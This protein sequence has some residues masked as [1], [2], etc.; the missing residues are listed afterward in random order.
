P[1]MTV[2]A[3]RDGQELEAMLRF[4]AAHTKG[5]IA[6]RYPRGAV[7]E[8]TG[9][10]LKDIVSAPIQEGRAE[11]LRQGKDAAF[12]AYGSM[13]YPAYEAAEHLSKEGIEVTVVNAR[14]VKPL[15]EDL[16]KA[17]A[18][19]TKLFVTLEEGS[20]QGGFGSAVLEF[21][22]NAQNSGHLTAAPRVR[23]L[24]IPDRFIEHGKRDVLMDSI[25]LSAQKIK[26]EALRLLRPSA[27]EALQAT[28]GTNG[29]HTQKE[30][31]QKL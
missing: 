15:D 7:A 25:G 29:H 30:L 8:E 21:F 11:I 18:K 22:E 26:E 28:N 14:F 9:S 19:D 13:V 2:M 6:V 31:W 24:G 10:A 1:G 23:V 4:G 3:P 5:P 17:L 20:V 12:L 16:L 27:R